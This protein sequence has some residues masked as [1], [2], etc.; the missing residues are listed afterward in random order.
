VLEAAVRLLFA[1]KPKI[2]A[3]VTMVYVEARIH[4]EILGGLVRS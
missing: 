3:G 4:P 1:F 2:P